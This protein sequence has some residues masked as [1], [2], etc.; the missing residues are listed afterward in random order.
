M[1]CREFVL[2]NYSRK[3]YYYNNN[4]VTEEVDTLLKLI[5]IG[6]WEIGDDIKGLAF[7]DFENW[8]MDEDEEDEEDDDEPR[9]YF[10]NIQI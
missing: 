6:K 8:E 1:S 10:K 9:I 7:D 2:V 4:C 5:R 3:E